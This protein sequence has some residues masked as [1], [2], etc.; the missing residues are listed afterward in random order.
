MLLSS[1][2]GIEL[3]QLHRPDV[4]IDALESFDLGRYAAR[5]CDAL[6]DLQRLAARADHGKRSP[7]PFVER[8]IRVQRSPDD[9]D[10][11]SRRRDSLRQ[12]N[13]FH[14]DDR[15]LGQL[16]RQLI[17]RD[18]RARQA[19]VDGQNRRQPL[20]DGRRRS[21]LS[22]LIARSPS[23]IMPFLSVTMSAA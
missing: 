7:P 19:I 9:R 8:R 23:R 15:R 6:H 4:M 17:F 5:F 22:E 14:R 12:A 3:S 1:S 21:D 18:V 11:V 10:H 16:F 20:A 2:R 13:P